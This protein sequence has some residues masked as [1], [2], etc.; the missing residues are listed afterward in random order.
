MIIDQLLY[1]VETL[2]PGKRIAI[3]MVGCSHGCKG[4]SNPELW[5]PNGQIPIKPKELYGTICRIAEENQVDGITITGGEPFDQPDDLLKLVTLLRS[6]T[7]DILV[8]S[9]YRHEELL[10]RPTAV[11]ILQQVAVLIDGP[12]K[13]ELN[14]GLP[15]RGSSN[16]RILLFDKDLKQQYESYISTDEKRVQNFYFHD[17]IVSVGIHDVGFKKDLDSALKKMSVRR[18]DDEESKMAHGD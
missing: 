14:A 11:S 6:L 3:W 13:E 2:G 5:R 15:L 1:P 12:Y 16:Q 8:F 9:G 4:C 18:A 7:A 10:L 17:Q